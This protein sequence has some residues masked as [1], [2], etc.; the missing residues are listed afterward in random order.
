MKESKRQYT[1]KTYTV[2][3]GFRV[4]IL[5]YKDEYEAWLYKKDNGMKSFMFGI[6]I[7]QRKLDGTPYTITYNDFLEK[8]EVN[9]K[10]YIPDYLKDIDTLQAAFNEEFYR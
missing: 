8:V 10:Y 9:V 2:K 3:K 7:R 4:D 6:P 5:T 1:V